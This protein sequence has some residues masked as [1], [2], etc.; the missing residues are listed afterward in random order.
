M[1]F[2]LGLLAAVVVFA[3]LDT[4]VVWKSDDTLYVQFKGKT[5]ILKPA[6]LNEKIGE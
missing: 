2:L 5:Y 3:L 6:E 4:V 1:A